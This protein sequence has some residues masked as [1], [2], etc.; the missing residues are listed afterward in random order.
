MTSPKGWY[1]DPDGKPSERYWDGKRWTSKTR[2]ISKPKEKT[3][4]DKYL[5]KKENISKDM[6][7]E[8]ITKRIEENGKTIR[9][10]GLYGCLPI[11]I[12]FV[13]SCV[14]LSN[15]SENSTSDNKN[16][17]ILVTP[18]PTPATSEEVD[19]AVDAKLGGFTESDIV[20]I[21]N[22][23]SELYSFV[24][25]WA[26]LVAGNVTSA[27]VSIYCSNLEDTNNRLRNLSSS[28]PYFEDLLDRVKDYVYETRSECEYAFKKNRLENL[29][30]AA[31]YAGTGIAFFD[32]LISEAESN[33]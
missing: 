28:S 14:V 8:E 12:L 16:V 21:K 4:F 24:E 11:F 25:S 26:G 1:P 2:P 31:E 23:R 22:G 17:E 19:L 30:Q 3:R 29:G 10:F 18:T 9:K 20:Q 33:Q 5:E 13:G 32:R 27:E 7:P 6:S 15:S